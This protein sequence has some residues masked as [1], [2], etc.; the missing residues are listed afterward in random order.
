VPQS[1]GAE[2]AQGWREVRSRE[3]LWVTILAFAA[4]QLLMLA[5]WQVLGPAIAKEDLGGAGAWAAITACWG[6][7]AVFGYVAVGSIGAAVG[8]AA[9]LVVSAV[10]MV[11]VQ[12]ASLLRRSVRSLE[13]RPTQ[14]ADAPTSEGALE[15]MPPP[16]QGGNVCQEALCRVKRS[17]PGRQRRQRCYVWMTDSGGRGAVIGSAC[18]CTTFQMPSSRRKMVVTRIATW[19]ISSAPPTRAR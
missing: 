8:L 15:P 7:G 11:A 17:G 19:A 10:L 5:T 1:L 2:L 16:T 13:R 14:H 12:L 6:V 4:F 18:L 9:T 3:W